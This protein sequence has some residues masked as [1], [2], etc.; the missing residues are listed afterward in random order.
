M[1]INFGKFY[2][3][4]LFTPNISLGWVDYAQIKVYIIELSWL[5]WHI[6]FIFRKKR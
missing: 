2:K 1:T 3:Y 4:I 6:I 5:C